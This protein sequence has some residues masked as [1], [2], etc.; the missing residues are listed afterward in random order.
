MS[1]FKSKYRT[2]IE[3]KIVELTI[4]QDNLR[5][6]ENAISSLKPAERVYFIMRRA[7]CEKAIKLLKSL[8]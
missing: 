1:L 4:E 3:K 2:R 6:Q 7:E 8:L 5:M